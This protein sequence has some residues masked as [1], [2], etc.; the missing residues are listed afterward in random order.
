MQQRYVALDGLRG[1]AAFIV[2]GHHLQNALQVHGVFSHGYLSVDFFFVLSGFVVAQAYEGRLK[3]G[4]TFGG[5]ARVRF[6]RLYPMMFVGALVGTLLTI[7]RD[8][9]ADFTALTVAGQFLL[10]PGLTGGATLFVLNAPYWSLFFE[11]LANLGHAATLRWATTPRLIAWT[12]LA[13]LATVASARFLH[14]LGGGWSVHNAWEGLVRVGF[15]YPT[16][17]LICRLHNAGRLPRIAVPFVLVALALLGVI[18][19]ASI[20]DNWM[21]DAATALVAFPLL[22][23]LGI[24]AP[25]GRTTALAAWMGAISYPLYA[26]HA[27]IVE[28]WGRYASHAPWSAVL[29]FFAVLAL[30][31]A[32]E[33]CLERPGR[34]WLAAILPGARRTGAAA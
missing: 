13:G 5:F 26:V 30:A 32:V 1:A 25:T 14:H 15:S 27:P 6:L 8:Q 12:V 10:I 16:G 3:D 11:V 31:T 4:L 21:A 34:R 20:I 22:L 19:A 29:A 9:A 2:V 7:A 33:A 17:V 18:A 28:L 24:N 23:G